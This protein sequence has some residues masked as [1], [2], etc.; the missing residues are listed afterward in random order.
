MLDSDNQGNFLQVKFYDRDIEMPYLSTE[1]GRP[2]FNT[3]TFVRIEIPGNRFNIIDTIAEQGHKQRFPV[4]YAAY[5]N[6]RTTEGVVNGTPLTEWPLVSSSQ[7]KELK[8]FNFYTVE[9][10]AQASDAQL[11]NV[12]MA[13]GMGG[14]AFRSKA[15]AFLDKAKDGAAVIKQ[16]DELMKRDQEIESLKQANKLMADRMEAL[17]AKMEQKEDAPKRGRPPKQED[18]AA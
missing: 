18:K 2:I 3:V 6:G 9:Q 12:G 4:E 10:I 15:Q 13:L 14:A 16:A 17:F 7:A 11:G 1:Q 8:H 5:M